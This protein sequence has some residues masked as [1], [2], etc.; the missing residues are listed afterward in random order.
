M[1]LGD[2]KDIHIAMLFNLG[3]QES[4]SPVPEE[5]RNHSELVGIQESLS[6]VQEE[7]RNHF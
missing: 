5:T 6:Q 1:F 2:R 7:T 4:P 3:I